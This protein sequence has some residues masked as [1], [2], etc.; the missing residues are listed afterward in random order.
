[1]ADVLTSEGKCA[2]VTPLQVSVCRLVLTLELFPGQGGKAWPSSA[3][4]PPSNSRHGWW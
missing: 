3:L 2:L 1:M 4:N